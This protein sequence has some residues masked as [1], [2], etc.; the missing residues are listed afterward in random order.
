MARWTLVWALIAASCSD[1]PG[2]ELE[3][4]PEA[5]AT[6]PPSAPAPPMPPP[7]PVP[8]VDEEPAVDELPADDVPAVEMPVAPEANAWPDEALDPSEPLPVDAALRARDA[9]GEGPWL[10]ADAESAAL[11]GWIDV[12]RGEPYQVLATVDHRR[13]TFLLLAAPG[14]RPEYGALAENEERFALWLVR[15]GRR[16]DDGIEV[17]RRE[18]GVRLYDRLAL[19][20]S[21]SDANCDVTSELR[22][23]DLDGD[24]EVELT[25]IAA[26]ADVPF[27]YDVCGAVAF[28]VGGD[29]MNV[30]ARFTRQF[31]RESTGVSGDTTLHDD[32]TWI[33]RDVNADGHADLHVVQRWSF[34]DDWGGDEIDGDV[35]DAV[36]R[37]GS[38]RREVDCIYDA[39]GDVWACPP[40]GGYLLGSRLFFAPADV[41]EPR[42]AEA[43]FGDPPWAAPVADVPPP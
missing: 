26:G 16:T 35:F 17:L 33:V 39:A 38:D 8:A 7:T 36:H 10:E 42:A 14:G 2:P 19:Y 24:E 13:R 1:P 15:V 25:A 12:D 34:R 32:A 40:V 5:P 30:Q 43:R 4:V 21:F 23:R 18:V 31:H 29:D 27:S 20:E 22:A 9:L 6:T 41:T 37:R 28:L 11:A 3:L